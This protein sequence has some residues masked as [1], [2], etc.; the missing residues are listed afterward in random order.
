MLLTVYKL[1]LVLNDQK[2]KQHLNKLIL[3]K[4]QACQVFVGSV[5]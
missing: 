1:L 3:S 5:D 2:K 4:I